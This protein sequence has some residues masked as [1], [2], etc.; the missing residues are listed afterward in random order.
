LFHT[1]LSME[2]IQLLKNESEKHSFHSFGTAYIFNKRAKKI[3]RYSNWLKVL[4]IIIPTTVG[5]LALSYGTDS[6]LLLL[7]ITIALPLGIFQLVLSVLAIIYKWDDEL[8]YSYESNNAHNS[9]YHD[10]MTLENLKMQF[11]TLFTKLKARE[12]QDE[13]HNISDKEL[14]LG[15]RHALRQFNWPCKGCNN[16]PTSMESTKC[17]VCG[18]F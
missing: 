9:L 10:F 12:E 14:R 17:D 8:A 3:S 16:I 2:N 13:K 15:M 1:N 18:N 6:H 7:A 4:G 11:N 5:G